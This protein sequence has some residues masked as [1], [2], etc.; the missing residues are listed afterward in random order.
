VADDVVAAFPAEIPRPACS[1][2][3]YPSDPSLGHDVRENTT[4]RS[5][6]PARPVGPVEE[7]FIVP[8]P[9]WKRCVDILGAGIGLALLSPLL[10][11]VALTVKA[12]SR[13]PIFFSQPRRGWGGRRFVIHKF[14]SMTTDAEEKHRWLMMFNEQD[15]AAFKM[16]NDPRITTVGRFLRKTSLDELPQLW[17]VLVGDMSLVGPRP[18]I[19]PEAD[20][21]SVWQRQ[22]LDITP[23]MTGIWQVRGSR[24][25][26]CST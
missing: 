12:T 5:A 23:G 17:N 7:L 16:K 10:L 15:G 3:Q 21:V 24:E 18:L 6:S 25:R 19:C 2:R 8:I 11:V 22:R 13:G 4:A 14:R 9:A 1:V 20:A 26:S